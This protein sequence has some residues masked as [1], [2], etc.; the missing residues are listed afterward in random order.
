MNIGLF[1]RNDGSFFYRKRVYGHTLVRYV[2]A[3]SKPEYFKCEYSFEYE[4]GHY[5]IIGHEV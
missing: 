2:D 1:Y 3:F 5:F 4:P